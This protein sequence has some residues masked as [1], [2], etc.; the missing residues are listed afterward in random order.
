MS[1]GCTRFLII[2]YRLGENRSIV[3]KIN[4]KKKIPIEPSII[5]PVCSLAWWRPSWISNLT[6]LWQCHT[7]DETLTLERDTDGPLWGFNLGEQF[8]LKN[9]WLNWIIYHTENICWVI[10]CRQKKPTR[11]KEIHLNFH[12]SEIHFKSSFQLYKP[13]K[14]GDQILGDGI[15]SENDNVKTIIWQDLHG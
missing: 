4:K 6:Y 8:R 15:H 13:L 7:S 10:C 12:C 11:S 5:L 2:M 1:R 3:F 9:L 14:R